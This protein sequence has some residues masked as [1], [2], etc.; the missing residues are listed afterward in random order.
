MLDEDCISADGSDD[1]RIG[2]VDEN[3]FESEV[4]EPTEE[5]VLQASR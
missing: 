1:D 5:E 2:V 4:F 3:W